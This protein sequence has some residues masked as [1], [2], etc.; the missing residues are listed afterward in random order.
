MNSR[1]DSPGRILRL[2]KAAEY[3]ASYVREHSFDKSR[4]LLPAKNKTAPDIR[5][6]FLFSD[7]EMSRVGG[8]GLSDSGRAPSCWHGLPS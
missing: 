6:G 7:T 2:S 8:K 5:G 3:M 1:P 4:R